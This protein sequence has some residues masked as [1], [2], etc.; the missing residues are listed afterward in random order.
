MSMLRWLVCLLV[1]SSVEC[2]CFARSYVPLEVGEESPPP[3]FV[4]LCHFEYF[5]VKRGVSQCL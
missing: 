1:I 4:I 5:N 2:L 3:G